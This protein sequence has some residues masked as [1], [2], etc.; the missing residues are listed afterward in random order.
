MSKHAV[1]SESS[2]IHSL[3]VKILSVCKLAGDW[4]SR[5][6]EKKKEVAHGVNLL[7][8]ISRYA[9]VGYQVLCTKCATLAYVLRTRCCVS[10]LAVV[11]TEQS[12]LRTNIG[13]A[14]A[15]LV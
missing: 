8:K 6:N 15:L 3:A 12:I 1:C 9:K 4:A 11:A 14:R 13:I 5:R 7:I 2:P 10:Y